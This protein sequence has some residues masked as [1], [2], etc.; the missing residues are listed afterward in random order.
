MIKQENIELVR[1]PESFDRPFDLILTT[2]GKKDTIF[3]YF[4]RI[5][6]SCL[7]RMYKQETYTFVSHGQT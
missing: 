3:S 1:L 6:L 5:T 7:I 2:V 4:A